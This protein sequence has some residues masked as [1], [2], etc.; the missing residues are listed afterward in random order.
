MTNDSKEPFTVQAGKR[1]NRRD[2]GVERIIDD[3]A[4]INYPFISESGLTYMKDGSYLDVNQPDPSDIISEYIEPIAEPQDEW[5]PWIGWNGGECPVDDGVTV[6]PHFHW[7]TRQQAEANRVLLATKMPLNWERQDT[8]TD[9]I[10]YRIKKE[11][12]AHVCPVWI[13]TQGLVAMER[14]GPSFHK[15][16]VT[17]TNGKPSIR[18]ADE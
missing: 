11:P 16:I 5:G 7:Q 13:N 14:L 9:I 4:D 3:T 15:A 12:E 10:A 18:W 8:S 1:Y 17:L 6:Q 2:G